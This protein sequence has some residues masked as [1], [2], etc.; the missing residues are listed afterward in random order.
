M[1]AV[2]VDR[3]EMPGFGSM[4]GDGRWREIGGNG[5]NGSWSPWRTRMS[6]S[7]HATGEY[8]YRLVEWRGRL[9]AGFGDA[10][11]AAQVWAYTPGSERLM[12]QKG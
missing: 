7:R 8:V 9:I 11:G 6:G 12:E 10:S 3:R 4:A 1:W 5:V 2:A